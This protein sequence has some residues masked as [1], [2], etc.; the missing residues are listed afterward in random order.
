[1]KRC[2]R[3]LYE[4]E[5]GRKFYDFCGCKACASAFEKQVGLGVPNG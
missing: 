1:M 3:K 5:G 2:A 4:G